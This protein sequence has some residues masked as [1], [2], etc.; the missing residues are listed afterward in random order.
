MPNF[1]ISCIRVL[2]FELKR[3]R[4]RPWNGLCSTWTWNVGGTSSKP[5]LSHRGRRGQIY[6]PIAYL[7]P[8]STYPSTVPTYLYITSHPLMMLL[9]SASLADSAHLTAF[10]RHV[11]VVL[12]QRQSI[13]GAK[14]KGSNSAIELS[15]ICC[16]TTPK[17][18]C[19]SA[20]LAMACLGFSCVEAAAH[21]VRAKSRP[22][23]TQ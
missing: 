6:M 8:L 22:R 17:C 11:I 21:A 3:P 15:G 16:H 14:T 20:F 5:P 19:L 2:L 12:V 7:D 1:T 9:C 18:V 10:L 4:D 23:I 13:R